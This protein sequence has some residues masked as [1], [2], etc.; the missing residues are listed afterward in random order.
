MASI[1]PS[2]ITGTPPAATST[3]LAPK[4]WAPLWNSGVSA[5]LRYFGPP[6]SVSVRSGCRRPTKP[7]IS[8]LWMI[9]NM[10]RSRNR[11][12]RRPVLATVATPAA[13]I[14]SP[15]TPRLR[16]WLTSPVQPAGAWPGRKRRSSVRSWPNRSAR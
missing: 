6:R 1:G 15:V 14:S 12:M 13:V 8:P 11:S 2:T 4:S 7:R 10:T 3:S 9:G 5:V 16:R